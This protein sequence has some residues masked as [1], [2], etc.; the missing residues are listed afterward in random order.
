MSGTAKTRHR[1]VYCLAQTGA[2][3]LTL[4]I[5]CT[6]VAG[7]GVTLERITIVE[8]SPSQGLGMPP[9]PPHAGVQMTFGDSR[10]VFDAWYGGAVRW[11][12]LYG[13]PDGWNNSIVFPD[14]GAGFGFTYDSGGQ[15]S[16]Q[17]SANGTTP[18]RI[19]NPAEPDSAYYGY[20]ARETEFRPPSPS[21]P[22]ATYEVTG[23]FPVWWHHWFGAGEDAIP[24]GSFSGWCVNP[25]FVVCGD[26]LD[27]GLPYTFRSTHGPAG[28]NFIADQF[29]STSLPWNERLMR[30]EEGRVAFS[31]EVDLSRAGPIAAGGVL[32]RKEVPT[33][34]NIGLNEAVGAPGYLVAVN[35]SGDIE[36][37]KRTRN[38]QDLVAVSLPGYVGNPRA[39]RTKLEVRT[40]NAPTL[41]GRLYL[42]VNNQL[43]A[44]WTDSDPVLGKHTGIY[45]FTQN[46]GAQPGEVRFYD[47][48]FYDVGMQLRARW[49]AY[50]EGYL[51]SHYTVENTPETD[52]VREHKW[53]S[54]YMDQNPFYAPS[55]VGSSWPLCTFASTDACGLLSTDFIDPGGCGEVI[56][57]Q[58]PYPN[59]A[60]PDCS[61]GIYVVPLNSRPGAGELIWSGNPLWTS[62]GLRHGLFTQH[63]ASS[64]SGHAPI[65]PH[66]TS[67]V[68]GDP[69]LPAVQMRAHPFEFSQRHI[70]CAGPRATHYSINL[71]WGTNL[72]DP[73]IANTD[74]DGAFDP[75]DNCPAVPNSSQLDS[76]GDGMGDACDICPN[77]FN[78]GVTDCTDANGDGIADAVQDDSDGDGIVDVSD[79]CPFVFNPDGASCSDCDGNGESDDFQ[80][81]TDSDNVID[82]CDPCPSIFNPGGTSCSDCDS[83]GTSDDLQGD[84]DGDGVI[85]RCDNCPDISNPQ[86]ADSDGDG[87][88]DACPVITCPG[89]VDGDGRVTT[90]D[91]TMVVS[92]LGTS[93]SDAIGTLGDAN[94]DGVTNTEDLSFVVSNLGLSCSS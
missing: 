4:G 83:N 74:G 8:E 20:Y 27:Q 7:A 47:R 35:T 76:D 13:N 56:L 80:P 62:P 30:I 94:H 17:I 73:F 85:D 44:D 22:T 87:I 16:T 59:P 54:A 45:A 67:I 34:P 69:S 63:I 75:C 5:A 6:Q 32:F 86:Q 57:S 26:P 33:G 24:G 82:A 52:L 84:R 79:P 77:I 48:K 51:E 9:D 11:W 64:S 55:V 18:N 89:D 78:P 23:F 50:P 3:A 91:L 92:N 14:A 65:K 49:T 37:R 53:M 60:P 90:A 25:G 36:I 81:D 72:I 10:V 31:V 19:Q 61:Y 28:A 2:I 93:T 70:G 42:Y 12:Y 43:A 68:G 88:G 39:S 29:L 38:G 58:P 21:D 1:A 15:D 41:R 46:N 71:R 66:L 40:H